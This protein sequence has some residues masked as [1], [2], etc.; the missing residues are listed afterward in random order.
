MIKMEIFIKNFKTD[1]LPPVPG[2]WKNGP[3]Q[4]MAKNENHAS[5]MFDSSN[6]KFWCT[7]HN[8]K[9]LSSMQSPISEKIKKTHKKMD[10]FEKMV[11]FGGFSW[12]FQKQDFAESWGFLRCNQ[13]IKTLH[14]SYQTTRY[15][16]FLLFAI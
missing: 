1:F 6:E 4:Y 12:F 15:H 3:L 13:F 10:I 16:D 8:A 5:G 9:N 14:L 2:G 11:I 7:D